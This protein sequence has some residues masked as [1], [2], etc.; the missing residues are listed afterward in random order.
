MVGFKYFLVPF[1]F[2]YLYGEQKHHFEVNLGASYHFDKGLD[3][4]KFTYLATTPNLFIGYRYQKPEGRINF[5]VG[6]GIFEILQVGFGYS[7]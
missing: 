1:F 2:P 5:K 6:S 4:T 7:F 3:E